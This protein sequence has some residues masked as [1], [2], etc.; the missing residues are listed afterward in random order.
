[1]TVQALVEARERNAEHE[2]KDDP[3]ERD[4]PELGAQPVANGVQPSFED[5]G[6][7]HPSRGP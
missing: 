7:L 5:G 3:E 2:A 1:M 4:R 6:K